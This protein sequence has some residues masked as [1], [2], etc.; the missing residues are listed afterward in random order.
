M[1]F[2]HSKTEVE[3]KRKEGKETGPNLTLGTLSPLI[4]KLRGRYNPPPFTL[5]EKRSSLTNTLSHAFSFPKAFRYSL[6]LS[7]FVYLSHT[8]TPYKYTSQNSHIFVLEALETIK[9]L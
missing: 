5:I 9:L 7:I 4:T 1:R 8:Q 6:F 3:E 2:A